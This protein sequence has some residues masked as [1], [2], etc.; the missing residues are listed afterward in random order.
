MIT[1]IANV[2]Y[3]VSDLERAI[4]FYRD[5]LGLKVRRQE[6]AWA[7]VELDGVALALLKGRGRLWAGGRG[8]AEVTLKVDDMTETLKTLRE[9]GLRT[10]GVSQQR[11]HGWVVPFED[12][13]G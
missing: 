3:L 10:L 8:G 7:E 11:P 9:R 13:D 4:G 6:A 1:G 2:F 12:P 5:I